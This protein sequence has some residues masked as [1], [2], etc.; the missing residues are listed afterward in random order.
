MKSANI[1]D[2]VI[3]S[4][5]DLWIATN[6]GGLCNFNPATKQFTNYLNDPENANSLPVIT[7]MTCILRIMEICGSAH[8]TGFV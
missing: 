6:Q 1:K 7:F 4:N 3:D 5:N 8:L 2:I